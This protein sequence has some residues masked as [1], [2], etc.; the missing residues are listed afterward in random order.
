MLFQI[1]NSLA[2]FIIKPIIFDKGLFKSYFDNHNYQGRNIL[3]IA[4]KKLQ[5]MLLEKE[6]NK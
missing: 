6:Y 5:L 4:Q 2:K 1:F 3:C